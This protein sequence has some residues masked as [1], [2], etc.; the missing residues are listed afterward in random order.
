VTNSI[1]ARARAWMNDDPS[2][3]DRAELAALLARA[4]AEEAAAA[5]LAE[6][7]AGPLEFGTAGLRGLVGAGESRM[8][9]AVVAR[10]T[11]GLMVHLRGLDP[12]APSKGV[13]IGRDARL[14]SPLL[15][16]VAAEVAAAQGFVV[17]WL[18]G[19]SPTPLVA[20]AVKAVGAAAGIALTASHNPP[21]YNGYKVYLGNGAQIIPP[22]D[23]QIA[24]C[25]AD[26]PPARAIPRQAQAEAVAAG[27]WSERPG[28][29]AEYVDRIVAL[30]APGPEAAKLRI[31]YTAMHGVGERLL[32]RAMLRA[33]FVD[34]H[35]AADQADPDGHFPT[36]AFPNPEEKG[37]MD[38]VL[39]VARGVDADL[40][41]A[42]DPDAD[43]LAAA[44]REGPGRYRMLSGN[45]I[46]VLLG[47]HA[48]RRDAGPPGERLVMTTIVSTTQL[49]RIAAD[50]GARY[51]ETL[52]GFKWIANDALAAA[53]DGARFLFGFE[54]AIG[55]TI[56][57]LVRDKDGLGAALALSELAASEKA[58][59][60][61][62]LDRLASIRREHGYFVT[63]QR[64]ATLPGQT[65][66]ARIR[67]IM[68]ELRASTITELGGL[69]VDSVWDLEAQTTTQ[70]GK[71][72]PDP[73]LPP[74]NVLI[75]ELAGGGRAAVRPSGTEPKIK[76]Y[77]EAAET[78]AEG[79]D[80]ATVQA[81]A[82]GTL[83]RLEADLVA[84]CGL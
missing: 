29:E 9:E 18:P 36:V 63:R 31:A 45:E 8:N 55:F 20:W 22:H 28:L 33:G 65:G 74:S 46:G 48:L 1:S 57:T 2:P 83:D 15:S 72:R 21:Q 58:A 25:I 32:T 4:D 62:L 23:G 84:R 41:L 75:Y 44:V 51:G 59:G 49:R 42:N 69:G 77:L 26:A 67:E 30:V 66:L 56:G 34:F 7:F 43:R 24:A 11:H 10:A 60:R 54:E 14:S 81:R 37:A 64:S 80:E 16:R 39:G 76:L 73:R 78:W 6:R 61:T 27:L 68:A 3:E 19:P 5:E 35:S 40:V 17:H 12:E 53:A 79:E 50:L 70:D 71:T 13:V 38:L 52:T 47:H 82:A